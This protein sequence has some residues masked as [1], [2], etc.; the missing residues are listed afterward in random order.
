MTKLS[1]I[2]INFNNADGL[3]KTIKSVVGQTF[4]DY[5]YIIID[6]GS[7]DGSIE[8]INNNKRFI[9]YWVSEPDKGIYNAMNKGIS[10]SKGDWLFFLNSGDIFLSENSVTEIINYINKF[11]FT[12]SLIYGNLIIRGLYED[13]IIMNYNNIDKYYLLENCIGQQAILFKRQIFNEIGYFDES[14]KIV[15]DYE[16]LLRAFY[17]FKRKNIHVN[18]VFSIYQWGGISNNYAHEEIH[19]MEREIVIS[20]YYNKNQIKLFRNKKYIQLRKIKYVG[21]I[22]KLITR[23]LIG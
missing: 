8:I 13:D 20:K 15:G 3:Q 12:N 4:K 17:K 5:E 19:K 14:L 18:S 11:S 1:I 7:T 22:I 21:K 23:Q 10:L 2:T 6:G 9:N 16:F